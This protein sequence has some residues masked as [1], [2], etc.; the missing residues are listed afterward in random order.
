MQLPVIDKVENSGGQQENDDDGCDWV[1][2]RCKLNENQ[3]QTVEHGQ[4]EHMPT[5]HQQS[6][7]TGM[8]ATQLLAHYTDQGARGNVR[9]TTTIRLLARLVPYGM[10]DMHM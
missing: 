5:S 1:N 9:N 8:I 10:L 2:T 3:C 4:N 6:P 7:S